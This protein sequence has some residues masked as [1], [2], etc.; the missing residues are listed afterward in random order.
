MPYFRRMRPSSD[1]NSGK[2]LRRPPYGA[3]RK[4]LISSSTSATT[5][6]PLELN[7]NLY[8][9]DDS[10]EVPENPNLLLSAKES[11]EPPLCLAVTVYFALKHAVLAARRDRGHAEWF[12][13]DVPCTVQ[14]VREAC[15]VDPGALNLG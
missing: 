7:T 10:P 12:R 9:R 4:S 1:G 14:R 8:P 3:S 5:T 11:G 13:L 6:V 2:M 15:L